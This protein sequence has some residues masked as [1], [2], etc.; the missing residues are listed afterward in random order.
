V[1]RQRRFG[2]VEALVGR[3]DEARSGA[4]SALVLRG[5]TRT[6]RARLVDEVV[7]AATGWHVVRTTARA[8]ERD[9]PAAGVTALLHRLGAALPRLQQRA[10]KLSGEVTADARTTVDLHLGAVL[11]AILEAAPGGE[12]VLLVVEDAHHLDDRSAELLMFAAARVRTE[13]LLLVL[14]CGEDDPRLLDGSV[15]TVDVTVAVTFDQAA[16]A[17]TAA[18]GL[19]PDA[20]V[21]T[22]LLRAT[23]RSPVLLPALVTALSDAQ[24]LGWRPLPIPFPA[25]GPPPAELGP[26]DDRTRRALA[27]AALSCSS[28]A[29]VLDD[30][31][32]R[33]GRSGADLAPAFDAG[34]VRVD[35]GRLRFVREDLRAHAAAALPAREV[36]AAHAALAAALE[37]RA[38][39][40]FTCQAHHLAEAGVRDGDLVPVLSRA[41]E[42][43]R[44]DADPVAA[45]HAAATT[46]DHTVDPDDRGRL[47]VAAAWDAASAGASS[48]A[49]HLA[50]RAARSGT[51]DEVRTMAGAVTSQ[52]QLTVGSTVAA[53]D[54]A[55]RDADRLVPDDPASAARA[56]VVAAVSGVAGGRLS[57]A[58][59]AAERAVHL[60][61]PGTVVAAEAGVVEA[62]ASAL[63][64]DA[65][66]VPS[67]LD[68]HAATLRAAPVDGVT[69]VCRACVGMVRTWQGAHEEA[70]R[71]LHQLVSELEA[72]QAEG[73]LGLPMA[74][75]ALADLHRGWW[76]DASDLAHR[77]LG[78]STGVAEGGATGDAHVVLALLAAS[79]GEVHH[80]AH[81]VAGARRVAALIGAEPLRAFAAA[82]EGRL[83][84]GMRNPSRAAVQ[85]EEA[86][87]IVRSQ[88]LGDAA[89][90][91]SVGDLLVALVT[92]G[93]RTDAHAVL[94][95]LEVEAERTG[96]PWTRAA[97]H[98][99]RALVALGD[100]AIDHLD[101][102]DE[103]LRPSGEPFDRGL[104]RLLAAGVHLQAGRASSAATAATSAR[105]LFDPLGA[106][107]WSTR[108]QRLAHEAARS[109]PTPQG[110]LASLSSQ[111]R[112]VVALVAGGRTNRQIATALVVSQKTVEFHLR[113]VFRKLGV[114][115]RV[116]LAALVEATD[117]ED[118]PPV[119]S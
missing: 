107:P 43:A 12:P 98:R 117:V 80:C 97:V 82:A 31:L 25:V 81:H 15:P 52:L 94:E 2:T 38:P 85:L 33:L 36:A 95:D 14:A 58:R 45:A 7:A 34:I 55:M 66:A 49:A 27:V 87:R 67:V 104:N 18:R 114:T 56:L 41:A 106:A 113:N 62:M 21:L 5:A 99:G 63:L 93:R 42:R 84:L 118:Q 69:V 54:A 86:A 96:T 88:G 75:L 90:V 70:R 40:E 51:S 83:D 101:R 77:V 100:D 74:G 16:D 68:R 24:L 44:A 3:L 9:V 102:A 35:G 53:H 78:L 47:L 30:G 108:A 23:D 71:E 50:W 48:W 20:A 79:R 112:R 73:W 57:A 32:A 11:V 8:A 61:P 19:V 103:L 119:F 91:R 37:A 26:L 115:S 13:G 64:G 109:E 28:D 10:A 60:A 110:R 92:A 1:V 22:R 105:E 17:I 46:A 111:E 39:D 65:G 4:G 59:G 76:Q 89:V 72:V 116:E 29:A 6:P